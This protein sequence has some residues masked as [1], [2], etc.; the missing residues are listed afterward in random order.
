MTDEEEK[1]KEQENKMLLIDFI[2]VTITL[3]CLISQ[4]VLT[5]VKWNNYY[6]LDYVTY[7]GYA[8]WALS[9]LFGIWPMITLR[10]KGGVKKGD[11]YMKTSALVQ[12]GLY[13]VVRHPQ[14]LAGIYISL[15]LALISQHWVV[16]ILCLPVII[17]T[18]IDAFNADKGLLKK[19]GK[20]YQQ[21][22][23]KVP[24]LNPFFGLI[25]LIIKR[26]S[27]KKNKPSEK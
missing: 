23:K 17:L 27:N 2:P 26:S 6:G 5:F 25:K 7:L 9:A 3:V 11:S 18:Y 12:S 24:P 21:Y 15:A 22:K 1:E 16:I 10:R 4:I 19:F 14:F 20:E 8:V 13:A